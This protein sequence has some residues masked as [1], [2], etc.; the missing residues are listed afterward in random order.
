MIQKPLERA[1]FNCVDH[2]LAHFAKD[3]RGKK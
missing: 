1:G 2:E 3:L